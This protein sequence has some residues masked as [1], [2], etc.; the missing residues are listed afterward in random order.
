MDT[1]H[2]DTCPICGSK[3][4]DE[5]G[6]CTD[7]YATGESFKI[8]RCLDCRFRFTQ[9]FPDESVI[10]RYYDSPDYISHSDTRR[11]LVNKIYHLARTYML[12]RKRNLVIEQ[13]EQERGH[14]LD[15]GAG[16]G[17]FAHE[18]KKARWTVTA[19]ETNPEARAFVWGLVK[20]NCIIQYCYDRVCG[21]S[22]DVRTAR[23]EKVRA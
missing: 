6:T 14:V 12:R 13:T 22:R 2:I 20:R 1:I 17:Y 21:A 3:R 15:I 16:T 10:A 19:A 4:L 8:W 11:G 9:D 23:E 18:M 5:A 7:H